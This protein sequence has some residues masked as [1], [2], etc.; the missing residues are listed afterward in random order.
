MISSEAENA[1]RIV[2]PKA[3]SDDFGKFE[4]NLRPKKFADY[5][6]QEIIRE[7]LMIAI[8]AAKGRDE[9]LDHVLLHGAPGLGKT[10]LAS[11]IA[12]EFG[13]NM[14][15]T[16]GP[17]LEKQ[18]DI[19]S[20]IS[21]LEPFDVLFIDEI[22]RLKSVVEEVLYTAMED[23]GIDII[24]GKGPSA[25]NMRINL[26][27]FTLIGA[28]TKVSMISAPLLSRFGNVFKLQFY[29]EKEICEIV[30]RSAKI[31]GC[32]LDMEV[33]KLI[34][35]CARQTPRIAN[36]LLKRVRDYADVKH[37]S[38]ISAESVSMAMRSLGID[39]I[40]LDSVDREILSIIIEKFR[41]GPVGLNTIAAAIS[42]EQSTVE[43]IYEPFL[44]QKGFLERTARGRMVT[45]RAYRHLQ[46]LHKDTLKN[47]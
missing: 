25:R 9:V 12:A 31:L 8:E 24:I 30:M 13:V 38:I 44:I 35:N 7:N 39:E 21:N 46:M 10:T 11:V 19:A 22:H 4:N 28:T 27:K 37:N 18:G 14:K 34:A 6:G 17:A 26:P 47:A 43:D 20:I 40:G 15:V 32:S 1:E 16:S 23:F 33:A 3:S 5:V 29:S 42:E 41:G 36:R 45:D 2:S